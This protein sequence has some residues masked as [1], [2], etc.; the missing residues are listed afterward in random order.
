MKRIVHIVGSMA[1]GG[2]EN[3]IM[4]VYRNIDREKLQFDFIVNAKKEISYDEEIQSMG[5][6]MFYVTRKKESPIKNFLEVRKI[7]KEE[8]FDAVCR[9]S[10]NA[11]TVTD[12]LAAKL[13]GAKKIVMHSHST[14]TKNTGLHKFF[15]LWFPY[16][17]THRFACSK[18]AGKWMYGKA[19]F[20]V[21]FN[22]ID[23]DKFNYSEEI[24]RNMRKEWDVE[25]TH[26]YGHVGS[27]VYAKNHG[28][29]IDIF[30][31]IAKQDEKAVLFLV[32]DGE[33]RKETEEKIKELGL[34]DKV[35]LTGRRMNVPDFLQ[36][37]DVLLFP[38]VYEGLPVSL[39]EAQT[40]G[41]CCL[42]SNR[43][44]D[45]VILT[46]CAQSFPIELGAEA[47]AKKAMEMMEVVQEEKRK[48]RQQVI[49][50]VGYDIHSLTKFY[51]EF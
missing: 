24:R 5:G 1:P 11:F 26:V 40:S 33:L 20:Q 41:L 6:R 16:V 37:F 45:E 9:H 7:I 28:F 34:E 19:D 17:T 12:L 42:V 25:N 50:E 23:T 10:D 22:A 4:N 18:T 27:F 32:G 51:E 13:A 8:K 3:F 15:R 47:W 43:I 46:D 21:V 49:K 31:L 30:H 35:I 36:M 29:L 38:S 39:V 48:S 44:T 14:Q 2:I